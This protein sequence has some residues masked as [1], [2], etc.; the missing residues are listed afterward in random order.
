MKN[1]KLILL[2]A[3]AALALTTY[4]CKGDKAAETKPEGE[5]KETAA[6]QVKPLVL[7]EMTDLDLSSYGFPILL[8]APKDAKV[9]KSDTDAEELYIYGGKQYKLTISKREGLAE[10]AVKSLGSYRFKKE[11]NP[12]PDTI[13]A[14]DATGFIGKD[15]EGTH[16][17]LRAIQTGP[18]CIL[19]SD[20][21]SYSQSPDPSESMIVTPEDIKLMYDAVKMSKAK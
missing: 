10:D 16:S 11:I 6:A 17:F 1:K 13:I 18:I 2:G 12:T 14:E 4:S 19:I 20:G 8:K 9:I 3:L 15:P 5:K 7:A 21:M